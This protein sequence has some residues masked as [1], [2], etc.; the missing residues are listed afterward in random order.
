MKNVVNNTTKKVVKPTQEQ[1]KARKLK[2]LN[3]PQFTYVQSAKRTEEIEQRKNDFKCMLLEVKRVTKL[4]Q[5]KY[6]TIE[7]EEFLNRCIKLVNYI[8]KND[9]LIVKCSEVVTRSKNGA[10][11]FNYTE[12]LISKIIKLED[13]KGLNVL[14]ALQ[15]IHD[16]KVSK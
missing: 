8:A 7:N 1:I 15:F 6:D 14:D 2:A 5:N 12:Q 10:F 3:N 4:S 11:Q 16:Q 13:K 9:E